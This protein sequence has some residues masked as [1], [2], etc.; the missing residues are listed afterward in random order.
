MAQAGTQVCL[1][2]AIVLS[3]C[4][5]V[6][7]CVFVYLHVAQCVYRAS[8]WKDKRRSIMHPRQ[9]SKLI[10]RP[11]I[12]ASWSRADVSPW[13]ELKLMYSLCKSV[14]GQSATGCLY[15]VSF[16]QCG[17]SLLHKDCSDRFTQAASPRTGSDLR[18]WLRREFWLPVVGD[19]SDNAMLLTSDNFE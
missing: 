4:V 7:V 18:I 8:A 12:S 15:T 3:V 19:V 10:L 17:R 14:S 6:C 13:S 11:C 9:Q 16:P 1:V 5:H 2:I